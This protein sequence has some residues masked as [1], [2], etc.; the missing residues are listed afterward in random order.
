MPGPIK[1]AKVKQ[2]EAKKVKVIKALLNNVKVSR[3]Q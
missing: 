1:T 3:E 2:N